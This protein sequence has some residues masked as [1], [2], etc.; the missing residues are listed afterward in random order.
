[1]S[2][3][4]HEI[5]P[6]LRTRANGASVPSNRFSHYGALICLQGRSKDVSAFPYRRVLRGPALGCRAL[7][8]LMGAFGSLIVARRVQVSVKG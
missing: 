5:Q 4:R 8:C 6:S 3:E 7:Q 1:M 2:H